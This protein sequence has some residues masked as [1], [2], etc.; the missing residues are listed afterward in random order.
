MSFN[1]IP[2]IGIDKE[3][4]ISSRALTPPS[5]V[6]ETL[7]FG[8]HIGPY[9]VIGEQW[10][11]WLP[12]LLGTGHVP[13]AVY[14]SNCT[15]LSS[16]FTDSYT[17][18][19]FESSTWESLRIQ[20]STWIFISGSMSFLESFY[21][22]F[23]LEQLCVLVEGPQPHRRRLKHI[24]LQWSR[25]RHFDCGGVSSGAYYFG[26]PHS[27]VLNPSPTVPSRYLEDVLDS[28]TRGY[29]IPV[30][31]DTVV[32]RD[33]SPIEIPSIGYHSKGLY[34]IHE[35]QAFVCVPSVFT[36]SK[37]CKRRISHKELAG[38]F[39]LPVYLQRGLAIFPRKSDAF[40]FHSGVPSKVVHHILR[41]A[42]FSLFQAPPIPI[43]PSLQPVIEVPPDFEPRYQQSAKHDD[44][45]IENQIW[46]NRVFSAFPHLDTPQKLTSANKAANV[47]RSFFCRHVWLRKVRRSFRLYMLQEYGSTWR[48]SIDRLD[49]SS[50]LNKDLLAY[51]DCAYYASN[52]T[53]FEWPA[54][55]R[56]F[57]WRWNFR[58]RRKARDGIPMCFVSRRPK[59]K[60]S[61]PPPTDPSFLDKIKS[62]LQKVR[63]RGYVAPGFVKS[64]IRYFA[65]P[66]GDADIRMVYDGTSSGF[67]DSIWVPSFGMPVIESVLR[68][69]DTYS[70]MADIDVA[71]QFLNFVLHADAQA[72]CGI[73]MTP[74]FEDEITSP[75]SKLWERWTRCLMGAKSS[76]YQTIRAMLWAEDVIRGNRHS[77][78]NPLRWDFVRL[79]LPGSKDYDPTLPWVSK[80]RSDGF[81]ASDFFIYVDDCR[82]TSPSL[83]E[84]WQTLRRISSMLGYLGIQDAA[85]KRRPPT[86]RPGAWAGSMVYLDKENVGVYISHD[87][88]NKVK[89][90]LDWISSEIKQLNLNLSGQ[91][92]I[93]APGIN[94][95]ELE[96]KRGFLVYASR[97][98]P[99]MTPYLKGI[100]HTLDGWR[101]GRDSD[102]WKET[103]QDL[104]AG[105]KLDRTATY[106]RS[107]KAPTYVYPV[108]RLEDDIG[109]LLKLF[110]GDHPRVRLVRSKNIAIALYGFGDASGSGFGS[111]LETKNKGLKIRYGVWGRDS[112]KLS[113]NYRELCNLVDTIEQEA[114]SGFLSGT[115]MFLFTDNSVAEGCFYKGTS[116]SKKLF[117]LVLRIRKIQLKYSLKLHVI[118]V[119]GTRMIVQGTDGVSRGNLLEGVMVGQN[120]LSFVPLNESA[121]DRSPNLLQWIR[122]WSIQEAELLTPEGWFSTGHGIVGGGENLDGEWVPEYKDSTYIWAPPPAAAFDAMA[123]LIKARH[124]NPNVAHI[125]VCPRLFTQSWRKSLMKVADLCFYVP[126]GSIPEWNENMHEPLMIGVILPFLSHRPWQLRRSPQV[127]AVE[128]KLREVWKSKTRNERDILRELWNLCSHP[129]SM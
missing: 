11:S 25:L 111:T 76:P 34:P 2:S 124:K 52:A 20:S 19:W 26:T 31:V 45:I 107:S 42:G 51:S 57:F 44:A 82:S 109:C 12:S 110:E 128:S 118:H 89:S 69:T 94:H 79:N 48:Y 32:S 6:T 121:M 7:S 65:V 90:H 96:R 62:K 120:M 33:N 83:Y 9:I 46:D 64:L 50:E 17:G 16:L 80:V 88:W 66:K 116:D 104:V 126:V 35:K 4:G 119:S 73:D 97:T 100:H 129:N 67:N 63:D 37:W 24:P 60:R 91:S 123:E 101:E 103:L 95:K 54:G 74:Y 61:Q 49:P 10:P 70:W 105:E 86:Q 98:Y 108:P 53:W 87:K 36:P 27:L 55:S 59:V 23:P 13:Q 3:L 122:S 71:D 113:S 75:L 41:R 84:A 114:E 22:K 127:L 21:K 77:P 29:Q 102:G 56:L 106:A 14:S 15:Q 68:A 78:D 43:S 18:P 93:D 5:L 1:D 47:L 117:E 39:D 125:F 85:R 92:K 8:S 38:V 30:T 112:N 72:Y 81:I 28:A 99:S 58:F 40:Q 115:E